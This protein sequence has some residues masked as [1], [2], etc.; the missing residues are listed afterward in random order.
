[1]G[2]DERRRGGVLAIDGGNSKT[3]VV[4]VGADGEVLGPRAGR[5]VPAAP[6]RAPTRPSAGLAPRWSSGRRRGRLAATD[7]GATTSRRTWPTRTCRS[8]SEALDD[9]VAAHGWGA[10]SAGRQRHLRRCCAPAS[11]SRAGSP[12]SAAPASTASASRRTARDRAVPRA[13]PHLRRLGRGR[14]LWQEA[15]WWAARAEDGRGPDTALRDGA[16]AH[17]GLASMADADRGGP[18][19]RAR[20]GAVPRADPGAVRRRRGGDAVAA[21]VVRRQAEE[22]VAL[23]RRGACAA[24]SCSGSRRRRGARRR[25]AHGRPP[26]ADRRDRRSCSRAARRWPAPRRHRS[27]RRRRGAARPGPHR[28]HGHGQATVTRD[29]QRLGL[30]AAVASACRPARWSAV[31]REILGPRGA[32][33]PRPGTRAHRRF[34]AVSRW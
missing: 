21:D 5:A 17:F 4:L 34:S 2:R 26:A 9:A 1:M 25:R 23:A 6:G 31:I 24:W 32:S 11:T 20:R 22:I 30:G 19:R 13:R 33:A 15:M 3:D 7:R 14:R 16:A 29:H 12:W 8:S 18:P 28:R 27:A 10:S